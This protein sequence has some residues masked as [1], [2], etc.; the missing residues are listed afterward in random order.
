MSNRPVSF[1]STVILVSGVISISMLATVAFG[2]DDDDA[3]L[4]ALEQ[5][6]TAPAAT[7][8]LVKK[9]KTR[10]IVFDNEPQAAAAPVP[11]IQDGSV[12]NCSGLSADVPSTA[13][14]FPIQFKV[15]SAVVAPA[16]V[17]VLGEIAKI[18]ALAPNKCV[19]VEGHT[20]S[21]GNADRNMSLSR[22][23]ADSVV[24]FMVE[25]TGMDRIRFVPIGK[26]STDPLKNLAPT[27]PTN[28]RVVFK[29]VN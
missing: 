27:D 1:F 25:K 29:V 6:V 24:R 23:R 16:S 7:D 28:R 15:G 11:A 5:A 22:D 10:A 8:N 9:P 26:G 18:I 13:V 4:K 2:A 19:L 17:K 3:K 20:D 14:D 12:Q 21:T